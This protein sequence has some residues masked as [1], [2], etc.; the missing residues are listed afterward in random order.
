MSYASETKRANPASM[1]LAIGVN[2]SIILA[3]ALSPVVAER[4]KPTPPTWTENIPIEPKPVEPEEK[5]ADIDTK[6]LEKV[7]VPTPTNKDLPVDPVDISTGQEETTDTTVADGKGGGEIR[8][9][10]PVIV[11]PKLPDPP[12]AIF[13]GAARDLRFARDFQPNYPPGLLQKEI[14]GTASIRVLIGTDGRVRRAEVVSASHPDF[15]A[16][17]VKQALKSWRFRPAT[18]GDEVVEDWQ[19]LTVKFEIN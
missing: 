2:G 3:V 1:A 7:Y 4:I 11:E 18:R 15:G 9:Q 10:D 13:R 8:I 5:K 16:A 17:A 6:P 14:E 19:T 12:P